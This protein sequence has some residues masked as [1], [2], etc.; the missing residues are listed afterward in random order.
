MLRSPGASV[1][2]PLCQGGRALSGDPGDLGAW[3]R[4]SW[5]GRGVSYHESLDSTQDEAL[6]LASGGAAHGHLVWAGSQTAGR[7]R[8]ERRWLSPAGSGLWFSV[9]LRP[10]APASQVVSLPLAMG[11]A[12][13]TALAAQAPGRVRLKWPNDVLL[14]ARKVAGILVD[15]RNSGGIVEH[16][17]V[18]VG[19][20][21]TAPA[22]GFDPAIRATAAAL[23]EAA[24]GPMSAV[25][26]L[27]A[28]L[29][30]M[31]REYDELL[32]RGPSGARERWLRL[33][34]TIGRDV[35]VR[36]GGSEVRGRAV[37]LDA[38]GN[39]VLD[40]GTGSRVIAYGEVEH[41]R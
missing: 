2:P 3:L 1:N 20:N 36:I 24:D 21:L 26:V 40:T 29:E 32:A 35:A 27:A 33:A 23:E 8:L 31:E 37:D 5:L 12:V 34:D 14:D 7:G 39:L 16:A 11:A 4:T 41:L 13:A 19:V 30:A 25:R 10:N 18:G 22:G 6:R 15:A 17:V 9:V 28:V 38:D